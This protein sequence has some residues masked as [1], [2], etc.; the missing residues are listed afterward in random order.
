MTDVTKMAFMAPNPELMTV[1]LD[2]LAAK[3][4]K[5]VAAREAQPQRQ[6][7]PAGQLQKLKRELFNLTERAKS[8]EVYANN[9]AGNCKLLESR[10]AD[11]IKQKKIAVASGNALAERNWEHSIS[12][13][14]GERDGVEREFNRAQRV[15]A[16]AANELKHWPHGER[17]AELEKVCACENDNKSP[18][19][20]RQ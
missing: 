4:K 3:H 17:V 7:G 8:T 15:A 11:A 1:N 16:Q 13:L 9:I 6:E 10:I 5:L 19:Q 14:E 12:R 2:E 20:P 18:K